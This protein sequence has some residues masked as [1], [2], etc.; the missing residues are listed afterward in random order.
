M[1]ETGLSIFFDQIWP[2]KRKLWNKE[3]KAEEVRLTWDKTIDGYRTIAERSGT[4]AGI[5]KPEYETDAEGNLVSAT[6]EVYKFVQ[7]QKCGFMGQAFFSEFVQKAYDKK[8]QKLVVNRQWTNAPYHQLSIAAERQALRKAFQE[9][10]SDLSKAE[11][12]LIDGETEKM[13][14]EDLSRDSVKKVK[15]EVAKP[16][17]APA[18]APSSDVASAK[19]KVA[20][21]FEEVSDKSGK[22][23]KQAEAAKSIESDN[24][25]P[26][27]DKEDSKKTYAKSIQVGDYYRDHERVVFR[28]EKSR[29]EMALALDSGEAVLVKLTEQGWEEVVRKKRQ[30]PEPGGQSWDLGMEYYDGSKITVTAP[31]KKRENHLWLG[32]DNGFKVCLDQWGKEVERAE[33]KRSHDDEST[34]RAKAMKMCMP[35]IKKLNVKERK[36]YTPKQVYIKITGKEVEELKSEHYEELYQELSK[37]A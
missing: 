21:A 28:S 9:I 27:L 33:R 18:P 22:A 26:S 32:L 25:S 6:V 12:V 29:N 16:A 5:G 10:N 24:R 3:K 23:K 4:Y 31:D 37:G 36:A 13:E 15:K 34:K 30:K 19:T 14:D 17:P 35:L 2:N 20:E 1:E 11:N 8:T 7:G